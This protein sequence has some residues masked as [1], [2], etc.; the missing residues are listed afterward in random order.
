[1]QTRVPDEYAAWIRAEAIRRK[2]DCP[3]FLRVVIAAGVNALRGE[4]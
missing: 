3:E 1:M 2:I 4:A